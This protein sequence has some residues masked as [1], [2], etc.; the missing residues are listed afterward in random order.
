MSMDSTSLLSL[1]NIFAC[2]YSQYAIMNIIITSAKNLCV[3][4]LLL[5]IFSCSKQVTKFQFVHSKS[6]IG[7]EP[8]CVNSTMCFSL[9]SD[10]TFNNFYLY[11]NDAN[12]DSHNIIDTVEFSPY[13]S[14]FHHLIASDDSTHVVLWETEYEHF[15]VIKAYCMFNNQLVTIGNLG[16][17][18]DCNNCESTAYLVKDIQVIKRNNSIEFA[19]LESLKH[20]QANGIAKNYQANK[21]MYHFDLNNRIGCVIE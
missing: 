21:F 4:V 8:F 20:Q 17:S 5:A 19:F 12:S 2:L 1:L 10:S 11:F 3:L 9:K 6:N 14:T 15:S 18:A 13:P 16:V 7:V